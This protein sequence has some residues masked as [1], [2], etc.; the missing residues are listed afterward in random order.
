MQVDDRHRLRGARWTPSEH[1]EARPVWAQPEL[2]V[3]HCVSLPEGEY[4]TGAAQR[5][6]LGRLDVREHPSFA[7][8]E[9]LKVAPHLFVARE[10][11]VQQFVAFD[12]QAW[13]A[14]VSTWCGREGCNAYSVGIELEGCIASRFTA[15]QYDVLEQILHALWRRYPGISRQAVVGHNEVAPDRKSDP[16]PHFDWRRVVAVTHHSLQ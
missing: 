9:G 2:V 3:I 15:E 11:S 6:F 5:L 14:G 16:G 1:C 7:D 12:K 4:G 13:H 8:L 10:G